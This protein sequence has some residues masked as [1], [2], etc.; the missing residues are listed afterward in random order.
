MTNPVTN[1]SAQTSVI[2]LHPSDNVIIALKD[3]SA[4]TVLVELS[5][6]L[7]QAVPRGHKIATQ[8]I[9][10]G[11]QVI[12]YGQIIGVAT[13]PIAPGEHIHRKSVV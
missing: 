10:E 2:R 11:A 7:P 1:I 12:R 8:G 4:G 13:R 3:L 9:S 5:E 6:A